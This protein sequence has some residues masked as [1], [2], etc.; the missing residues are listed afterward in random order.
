MAL[1]SIRTIFGFITRCFESTQES[2]HIFLWSASSRP[3][4]LELMNERIGIKMQHENI[5]QSTF[6]Y[7]SQ[8]IRGDR[9]PMK[10]RWFQTLLPW[11]HGPR[12]VSRVL[13]GLHAQHGNTGRAPLKLRLGLKR[14]VAIGGRSEEGVCA[15]EVVEGHVAELV[16]LVG[17]ADVAV[18]CSAGGRARGVRVGGDA[19]RGAPGQHAGGHNGAGRGGARPQVVGNLLEGEKKV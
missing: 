13:L 2:W 4:V 12:D 3:S 1:S 6:G 10:S 7:E 17:K 9:K 19:G 5:K 18:V 14:V 15:E 8:R 11:S 16:L